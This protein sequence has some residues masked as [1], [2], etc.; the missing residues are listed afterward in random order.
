MKPNSSNRKRHAVPIALCKS[1]KNCKKDWEIGLDLAN[2]SEDIKFRTWMI[3]VL[4][5]PGYPWAEECD[6]YEPS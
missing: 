3:C 2:P 1:C 5:L 4:N 6:S